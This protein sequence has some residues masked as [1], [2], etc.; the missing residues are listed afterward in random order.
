MFGHKKQSPQQVVSGRFEIERDGQIAY[1]EYQLGNGVLVLSH[2]EVPKDLRGHGLA[3]KLAHE[4]LEYAREHGL[5]V[6]VVCPSVND[7]L[8]SHPEYAYLLLK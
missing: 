2:T 7:Y 3:S 5:K 6:D 1:L 8:A 4:S